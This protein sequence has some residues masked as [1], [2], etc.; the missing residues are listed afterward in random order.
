MDSAQLLRIL[1]ERYPIVRY[2]AQELEV[3]DCT[4][5]HGW[6]A[7]GVHKQPEGRGER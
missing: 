1:R 5:H 2:G 3:G 4:A 6:T 7:H